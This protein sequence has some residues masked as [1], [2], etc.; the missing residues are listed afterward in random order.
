MAVYKDKKTGKWYFRVYVTDPIINK[1]FQIQRNGFD[2]K[3]DAIEAEAKMVFTYENREVRLSN[4]KF[5]ELLEEYLVFQKKRV[6]AS[7]YN[8]YVYQI[9]KH[10]EPYFKGFK[11]NDITRPV[12]E[13]WYNHILESNKMSFRHKNIILSRLKNIIEYCEDQY[14]LKIRYIN[15]FP[16]FKN[17][18]EKVKKENLVIYDEETFNKFIACAKNQLERTI[19]YTMFYTGARIG[20]IRALTWNDIDFNNNV[21]NIDKQAMS[22]VAGTETFITKPKTNSSIRRIHIPN[23][24]VKELKKW[25]NKR[26]LKNGF[27]KDWRVFG[28]QGFIA[29]NTIRRMVIRM[30]KEANTP[31]ITLHEFRHSYTSLLYSKEVDPKIMQQQLGHSSINITMDIYTHLEDEKS[32]KEI[33]NIFD[34]K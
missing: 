23:L 32:K 34:K 3:R 17:N 5:D 8:S 27:N 4:L 22:K 2:L 13:K 19:F 25:Y 6:R 11:I 12:L 9:R 33:I 15:T 10:I 7:T 28:D 16:P 20:E 1:R 30:S 24:L 21:I 31:Y 26:K 14:D 29:Q 18:N